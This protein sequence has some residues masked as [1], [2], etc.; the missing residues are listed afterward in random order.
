MLVIADHY[1]SGHRLGKS[2]KELSIRTE[3]R[4]R[5]RQWTNTEA[6]QVS[7]RVRITDADTETLLIFM[8][9]RREQLYGEVEDRMDISAHNHST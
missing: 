9:T 1:R 7:T 5:F 2:V 6:Q 3:S 4:I 8:Q